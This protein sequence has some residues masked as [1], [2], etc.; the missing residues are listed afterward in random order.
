MPPST[1]PGRGRGTASE[2]GTPPLPP[3]KIRASLAHLPGWS[4]TTDGQR[5]RREWVVKDFV[6]G[7]EFFRRV[8]ELAEASDHHPDL[9]L[10]SYRQVAVELWTHA[11]GGLTE[12]D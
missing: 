9:H 1:D 7:L 3:E 8:G 12:K 5:I 2:R 10:V 6:T 11:A 4:L